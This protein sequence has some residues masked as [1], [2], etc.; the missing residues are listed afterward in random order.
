MGTNL[1]VSR[2]QAGSFRGRHLPVLSPKKADSTGLYRQSSGLLGTGGNL[3]QGL[4]RTGE[5][6]NEKGEMPSISWRH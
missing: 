5:Q 3:V 4:Q 2:T 1:G 6:G